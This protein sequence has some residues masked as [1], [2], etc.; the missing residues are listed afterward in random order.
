MNERNSGT[1]CI[2]HDGIVSGWW[3]GKNGLLVHAFITGLEELRF[4]GIS[5]S[6]LSSFPKALNDTFALSSSSSWK[7]NSNETSPSPVSV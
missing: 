1:V 2:L 6:C 7:Y 3:E 4:Q 5:Y